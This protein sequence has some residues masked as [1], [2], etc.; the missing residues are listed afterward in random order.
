MA[1]KLAEVFKYQSKFPGVLEEM[2]KRYNAGNNSM[3]AVASNAPSVSLTVY[4]AARAYALMTETGN[5]MF[6]IG[7]T[8]NGTKVAECA[9]KDLGKAKPEL[10]DVC[11]ISSSGVIYAGTADI[12]RDVTEKFVVGTTERGGTVILLALMDEILADEEA[13]NCYEELKAGL[14]LNPETTSKADFEATCSCELDAWGETLATLSDN[15]YQRVVLDHSKANIKLSDINA[16]GECKAIQSSKRKNGTYEP[17]KDV[18]GTFRYFSSEKKQAAKSSSSLKV[19]DFAGK[20]AYNTVPLSRQEQEMVPKLDD[21]WVIPSQVIKICNLLKI[22]SGE[23]EPMRNFMLK[24]PAGTGKTIAAVLTAVGIN[25]PKV[26]YTCHA[27][28]EIFDFVGQVLPKDGTTLTDKE[29]AQKY[30]L[31]SVDDIMFNMEEAY[32]QLTGETTLPLGMDQG[33]VIAIL[34]SKTMECMKEELK[35]QKDF[36]YV[37][38]EFIKAL[39]NG[40]LVEIQEPTVIVRPGVLVGLIS[41]LE[42]GG[43]ITLPTGEHIKRHKDAVVLV[44]TNMDYRGCDGLNQS[45]VSRMDMVFNMEN[46]TKDT[47]AQRAMER[48]G[49]TNASLVHEMAGI[50]EDIS[51]YCKQNEI[52]D[53]VC[54][55][56]E[57]I[58]WVKAVKAEGEDTA[59]ENCIH[60]VIEKVTNDEEEQEAIKSSYLE[61]STFA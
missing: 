55:M 42:Q 30:N 52:D 57:L 17:V 20:Y 34:I 6:G 1:K 33:E 28:T 38:T 32:Q 11:A 27:D 59:Y 35:A 24:G 14:L 50:I 43:T 44:T 10:I 47:M 31:P 61:T 37:E 54:G 48:T 9:Y 23:I 51:I 3:H 16:S 56:R 2:K 22:T 29:L 36:T 25:K 15:I 21:R 39:K 49:Y 8:K 18:K 4:K 41:L 7:K 12:V 19:S 40:W 53:G 58:A 46:P 13:F 60:C 45:V 26:T 5:T